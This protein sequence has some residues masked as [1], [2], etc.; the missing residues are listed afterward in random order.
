MRGN[1]LRA[2]IPSHVPPELVVEFDA[3]DP[4]GVDTGFHAAWHAFST[5]GVPEIV[6]TP[7]NGG[8]WLATSGRVVAAMYA[9]SAKFSSRL[10]MVPKETVGELFFSVPSSFDRPEHTPFRM[11]INAVLAPKLINQLENEIR[12]LARSLIAGFRASGGCEFV[13]EFANIL[14]I[15]IFMK[16]VDLPTS[17]IGK[18]K[19]LNDHI[20]RPDGTM[21]VPEA[22]A[23]L[24]NYLQ[25]IVEARLGGNGTDGFSRMINGQVE[26]RALTVEE[27]VLLATTVL[28]GGIDTVS[29]LLSFMM[30]FLATSPEHRRQ[31]TEDPSILP[32]AV[33]E[34][35]RRF[36]VASLGR[37]VK[38][39]IVYEGVDM[40]VGDM[41]IMPTALHGLDERQNHDSMRVDFRR[42]ERSHS[43][44]GQGP[45]RCPGAH[46]ARME[47]RITIEEWL[48][49]IPDFELAE[50]DIHFR[51]GVVGTVDALPLRWNPAQAGAQREDQAALVS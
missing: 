21:S 15:H 41:V 28:Q 36:P 43:A 48:A 47:V 2:P 32:A 45:H 8:H 23:G 12:G 49:Q 26:G 27:A 34:I 24:H 10:L 14:P 11:L 19:A 42:T 16:L 50:Q 22:T 30:H 51:G 18:L 39:D 38:Q 46:I 13:E 4:P 5:S 31:L 6:W 25:S 33:D 9:D 37:E 1:P 20:V 40:R 44:F 7:F 35:A 3:Y 17:D 29:N